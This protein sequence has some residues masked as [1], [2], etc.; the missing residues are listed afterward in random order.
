MV[1]T[2][3]IDGNSIKDKMNIPL[4]VDSK[5]K[6]LGTEYDIPISESVFSKHI[7][8]TGT[9]GTGKTTAIF[10]LLSQLIPEMKSDDVMVIFDT[11]G[12]FKNKFFRPGKD[13]VISCNS[14]AT[15]KWNIFREVLID[16]K[17]N[18]EENL[19]EIVNSLFE[20]KIRRS[21]APFFPLL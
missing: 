7:L 10:Q 18:S 11:K 5:V 6:L 4:S 15:H 16:G 9:I 8:Y 3:I 17:E 13:V 2:T 19:L 1:K 20:E 21:N 12:D 14:D